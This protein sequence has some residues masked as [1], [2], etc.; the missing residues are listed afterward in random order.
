MGTNILVSTARGGHIFD[1]DCQ[2]AD[3]GDP[4]RMPILGRHA[5]LPQ[6]LILDEG[7][8]AAPWP[9]AAE[10]FVGRLSED[11]VGDG[12][13]EMVDNPATYPLLPTMD[14]RSLSDAT[15]S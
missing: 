13:D 3:P 7:R 9:H 14:C 12:D 2:D 6:G 4:V 10:R 11:Q 15:A 5:F 1:G 8:P